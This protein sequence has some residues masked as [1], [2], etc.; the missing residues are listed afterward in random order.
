MVIKKNSKR[1]LYTEAVLLFLCFM[2]FVF[3][4][5]E[6]Y[7]SAKDSFFFEGYELV[8]FF[9]LA[10]V[11]SFVCASLV[12]VLMVLLGEKIHTIFFA[13][14]FSLSI[15]LYI[16]GNYI[17]ADYGQL[18][19]N[20]INWADYRVEGLISHGVFIVAVLVGLFLL[21]KVN[22]MSYMKA[23]GGISVCIILVQIVTLSTLMLQAG[24]LAKEPVYVS[25]TKGEFDYSKNENM[26][27]IL[28]D[29]FD[30]KVMSDLLNSEDAEECQRILEDFTYYPDA[31]TLYSNTR[32]SVPNIISG[33]QVKEGMTFDEFLSEA[34][35]TTPF[36]EEL[37]ARGWECRA[38][39]DIQLPKT[40]ENMMFDNIEPYTLKVNS[41]RRLGEY[42]LKL[43][44]F[45]YLPQSLKKYCWFYSDDMN[46]M[47][48]IGS[49][50]RER[51]FSWAN[52]EFYS[53]IDG[54]SASAENGVYS[55]YHLEGT[56]VPFK[57]N[58]DLTYS[59]S[60]VTIHEEGMAMMTLLDVF[61]EKLQDLGIYD[62]SIII[63][64][65]DHGYYDYRPNSLFLV[66]GKMETHPFAVSGMP[67]SFANLQ[68]IYM[69]LINGVSAEEAVS[70]DIEER[71]FYDIE[72]EE[73]RQMI[74][75]GNVGKTENL[76]YTDQ[77]LF[78]E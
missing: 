8:S 59:D 5:F 21:K 70:T 65:A 69:R 68:E 20:A 49:E 50:E 22:A 51:I 61:F 31:S 7:L 71:L 6:I 76:T 16:Q 37:E 4:P 72:N 36:L 47:I 27:I 17:L 35:E 41:H 14:C 13:L 56:H 26:F 9:A 78:V 25:T 12:N 64:L 30:S 67:V 38:F 44:G 52:M 2:L 77:V 45:R 43:I 66:K 32:F 62:N 10:F 75:E 39:T 28:M 3:A 29:T 48:S 40:S 15:A 34:F 18:D 73:L 11:C 63:V 54:I 33:V 57:T 24:G 1:I 55:F 74:I 23:A 46:A 60:E 42:M 19:G 53:G 58:R